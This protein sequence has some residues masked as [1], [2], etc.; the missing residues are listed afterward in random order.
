MLNNLANPEQLL[1]EYNKN[2]AVI[3]HE[4]PLINNK[5]FSTKQQKRQ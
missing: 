5:L 4:Y 2:F 3:K 1:G